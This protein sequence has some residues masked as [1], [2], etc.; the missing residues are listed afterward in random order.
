MIQ[1]LPPLQYIS[2]IVNKLF[3]YSKTKPNL[4]LKGKTGS[5]S[6]DILRKYLTK[7]KLNFNQIDL[8]L[9]ENPDQFLSEWNFFKS[10]NEILILVSLNSMMKETQQVIYK[11]L[12]NIRSSDT[13]PWII[14]LA[15]SSINGLVQD[16]HFL[17]ELYQI[18]GVSILEIKPISEQKNEIPILA[19][20]YLDM[21]SKYY[22]KRLKYFEPEFLNVI[23]KYDFPGDLEEF[24]NLIHQCVIAGKGR[25]LLQKDIPKNFFLES[26][27]KYDRKL[28]IIPGVT[29]REYEREI[30]K[31]NL[32]INKGNREI[33]AKNL[34]ISLRTL[35][36]KIDEFGLKD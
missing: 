34:D 30:I 10:T 27:V 36:R 13:K 16:Y 35:Y 5:R 4:I 26:K 15:N 22:K 2:N 14:S 19:K 25:T 24:E 6:N 20:Y 11:E 21:Y 1:E 7:F 17:R 8:D 31:E 18:L 23:V 3:Y 12:L 28:E 32:I 9:V 33:T 29:M